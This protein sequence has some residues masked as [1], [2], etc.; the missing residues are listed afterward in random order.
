[1]LVG[2]GPHLSSP[3]FNT[4]LPLFCTTP[5][6]RVLRWG[7]PKLCKQPRLKGELVPVVGVRRM[8]QRWVTDTPFRQTHQGKPPFKLNA[9]V[10]REG[11]P[12]PRR[13]SG[14]DPGSGRVQVAQAFPLFYFQ[15]W[16]EEP[17]LAGDA[18]CLTIINETLL[19]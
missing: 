12:S 10:C 16:S 13:A 3:V 2:M 17:E 1:M 15:G 9:P 19:N 7:V 8:P 11:C 6:S 4:S 18:V 5:F 14:L